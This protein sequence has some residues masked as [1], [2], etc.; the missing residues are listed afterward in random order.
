MVFDDTLVYATTELGK[1]KK[2]VGNPGDAKYQMFA[3]VIEPADLGKR[4][5]TERRN[6]LRKRPERRWAVPIP[7][8][9][10]AMAVAGP[11]LAAAGSPAVTGQR[12]PLNAR[13]GRLGAG[14]W[15]LSTKDGATLAKHSLDAPP[16][17][18][19]MAIAAGRVYI[20]DT[21]GELVCLAAEE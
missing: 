19:G 11:A 8:R 3:E 9:V 13:A 16:V 17:L 7:M 21:T 6:Y 18:N 15:L 20:S 5:Y 10:T 12:D 14:L 2:P 1:K 4:S